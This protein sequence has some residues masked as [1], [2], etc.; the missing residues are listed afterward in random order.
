MSHHQ[1]PE[2]MYTHVQ[3]LSRTTSHFR[4][5]P[6]DRHKEL[7]TRKQRRETCGWACNEHIPYRPLGSPDLDR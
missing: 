3:V 2:A 6:T 1:K 5:R 7:T 4:T